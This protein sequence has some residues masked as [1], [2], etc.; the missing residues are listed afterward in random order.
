MTPTE[1]IIVGR[2]IG[3]AKFHLV[4]GNIIA[5][6]KDPGGMPLDVVYIGKVIAEMSER[7]GVGRVT[8]AGEKE[9]VRH[10]MRVDSIPPGQ[11]SAAEEDTILA[12]TSVEILFETRTAGKILQ[13]D[14]NTRIL[15][16]PAD[17]TLKAGLDGLE[18]PAV[19]KP[20]EP[21]LT[22]P[23]D[24]D[25]MLGWMQESIVEVV[26]NVGEPADPSGMDWH[27]IRKH[28]ADEIE[29]RLDQMMAEDQPSQIA[30]YHRA[31]GIYVTNMCR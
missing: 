28:F 25:L 19:D 15:V 16:V 10:C 30:A 24:K 1:Y 26:V 20:F 31:V 18:M 29:K 8:S 11:L 3:E 6:E 9:L 17:G 27:E 14:Q 7:E 5:A 13:E 12:N 22:Y 4:G 2:D 23:I 21:P